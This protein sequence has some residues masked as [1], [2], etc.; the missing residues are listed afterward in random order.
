MDSATGAQKDGKRAALNDGEGGAAETQKATT[1]GDL[2][3]MMG[4]K[5]PPVE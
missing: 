2:S 3:S 4:G 5:S 1:V